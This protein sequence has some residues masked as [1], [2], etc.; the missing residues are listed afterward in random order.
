M[1]F[2]AVSQNED[3]IYN[4]RMLGGPDGPRATLGHYVISSPHVGQ[5]GTQKQPI[6]KHL[7]RVIKP[8]RKVQ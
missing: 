8:I 2:K 3:D 1:R 5:A 4:Y 6:Y 7:T